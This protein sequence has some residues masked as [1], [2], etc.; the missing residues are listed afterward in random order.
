MIFE[1]FFFSCPLPR[2]VGKR[3]PENWNRG[4]LSTGFLGVTKEKLVPDS[5]QDSIEQYRRFI[6][7]VKEERVVWGLKSKDGWA[8]APSNKFEDVTVIPFWSHKTYARRVANDEWPDSTPTP[9]ELDKF[10]D[11]WLKGMHGDGYLVG[12]NWNADLMGKEVEPKDLARD[13]SS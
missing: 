11:S 7:F 1:G 9:I 2:V 12:I 3:F 6:R 4:I 8:T 5:D 13:L 10:V